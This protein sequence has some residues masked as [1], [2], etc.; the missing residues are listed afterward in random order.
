MLFRSGPLAKQSEK[1]REYLRLKEELK[2]YEISLFI[3]DYDSCQEDLLET[4]TNISNAEKELEEVK[5]EQESTKS[6]FEEVEHQIKEYDELLEQKKEKCNRDRLTLGGIEGEIR[7]AKEKISSLSH[8]KEYYADRMNSIQA[9]VEEVTKEKEGYL[10]SQKEF[11]GTLAQMQSE[12]A[13]LL[14]ETNRLGERIREMEKTIAE[15]NDIILSS[16]NQT[17]EI[18]IEH[19]KIAS[20]MEQNS[21]RKAELNQ[22]ILS[23]KSQVSTAVEQMQQEESTLEEIRQSLKEEYLKRKEFLKKAEECRTEAKDLQHELHDRQRDYHMKSSRLATLK[24]ITERYDGYGQ[25]IRRVMEQKQENPGIVGVVA[26]IIQVDKKYE[27]AVETALGGSIQNI[28]TEDENTARDMINFLKKHRYGRATFLP[29]TTVS[30][31]AGRIK[32]EVLSEQGVIGCVSE[33][34]K[35]DHRFDGLVQYLLGRFV[36]VDTIDHAMALGRKFKH[37][38]LF[39]VIEDRVKFCLFLLLHRHRL[40]VFDVRR[41]LTKLQLLEHRIL[42][43]SEEHTSELQ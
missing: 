42:F 26:D 39:P 24:N 31:A 32:P 22:R 36:L 10:E 3:Q 23:N 17:S 41:I 30:A 43:R 19:Q 14:T 38:Q 18:H 15:Q 6:Q 33:L 12:E 8:G 9:S 20:M 34:V 29:L 21:I 4:K 37:T 13:E 35:K 27:T 28:V 2:K 1:A 11:T 25:S 5:K 7:I 16:M 40:L